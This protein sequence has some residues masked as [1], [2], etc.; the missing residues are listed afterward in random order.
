MSVIRLQIFFLVVFGGLEALFLSVVSSAA[1]QR[2]AFREVTFQT[3]VRYWLGRLPDSNPV[4]QV[5]SLML[6]TMS[7]HFSIQAEFVGA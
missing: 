5:Y 4:L 3:A 1:P 2:T 6:L 7:Y